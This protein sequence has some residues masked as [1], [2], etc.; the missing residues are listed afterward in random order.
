MY[1]QLQPQAAH[2]GVLGSGAHIHELHL[3]NCRLLDG[4]QGLAA[5]L[6][7]LT[8]LQHLSVVA[9]EGSSGRAL[10]FP[11]SS[12][13]A[14]QQLTHLQLAAHLDQPNGLQ[15]L[16]GLTSLQDLRLEILGDPTYEA[17]WLL[18]L[19]LLTRLEIR[20]ADA[21]TLFEPG[22]LSGKP[23]LQ[24]FE[25][26]GCMVADGQAGI[27]QLLQHLQQT[28][29]LEFLSLPGAV[30]HD[31]RGPPATAYAALTA[32]S[33]LQHLNLS[34]CTL[35][36]GVW[37]HVFPTRRQLPHLRRLAVAYIDHPDSSAPTEG[38]AEMT[39]DEQPLAEHV[40]QPGAAAIPDGHRLV[41][42]CRGLQS[43]DL[44][45]LQ[46]SGELLT[47]LTALKGL[48]ELSLASSPSPP[49]GLD[50]LGWM[51]GLRRLELFDAHD[52]VNLLMKLAPLRQLTYLNYGG[53]DRQDIACSVVSAGCVSIGHTV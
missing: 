4:E 24:H 26:V 19:E 35:P 6:P 18:G 40:T 10:A 34:S 2:L 51:T 32:S 52:D 7:L 37:Q 27:T 41:S 3:H 39:D 9:N 12:L 28:Q 21:F 33:K 42:C 23:R 22:V 48:S 46:Y 13:Q 14:L 8:Q 49:G 29:Q 30:L 25:V 45:C 38:D 15:H 31:A 47:P 20:G 5:A 43:L 50:V 36:T 1:L 17:N 16:Q 53:L 44:R 11:S